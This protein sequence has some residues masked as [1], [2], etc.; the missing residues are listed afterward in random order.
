MSTWSFISAISGERTSVGSGRSIAASWYVSDFPDPVGISA[1]V[2]R[3]STAARTTSSCPGR[4]SAKPK[5]SLEAR[6]AG[7]SYEQVY[8]AVEAHEGDFAEL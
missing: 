2:S 6:A 1:S 5:S 8:G 7:R 3:P 4:K